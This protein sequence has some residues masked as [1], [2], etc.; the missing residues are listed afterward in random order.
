MNLRTIDLNLLVV[1]QQL[2]L[3]RHVSRAAE[4]LDMSQPAVSRALRRLRHMLGDELLV[5]TDYGYDLSARAAI[6]LPQLNQL[7]EGVDRLIAGPVFEP[8]NSTRIVRFYGP[9]PDVNRFLPPL[10][11]RMRELAPYM[12]LEARSDPKDHFELLRF[13]DM[14]FVL[15]ALEPRASSAQLHRMRLAKLDLAIVMSANHPLADTKLTME[16][17]LAASH[18]FIALTGRGSAL[19]EQTL[20]AR[21]LLANG[22]RLDAPLSLSSF[23]SVASFCERSDILFHLPRQF[24]EQLAQGWNLVVR[25]TLPEMKTPYDQVYLYWHERYHRDPM[26]IWVREQLKITLKLN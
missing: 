8:A 6:L 15:S 13:G 4:Q 17:Y 20:I 25:D 9:D 14:H 3:E 24:A 26:C 2:L 1:L 12:G 19:V 18:G 10:F 23:S 7:L 16:K 5:R 21:G 22:E 11:A